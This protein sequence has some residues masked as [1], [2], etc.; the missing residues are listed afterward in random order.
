MSQLGGMAVGTY[1][2]F[3]PGRCQWTSEQTTA[4]LTLSSGQDE[5]GPSVSLDFCV[6]GNRIDTRMMLLHLA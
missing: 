1:W 2:L 3:R 5:E 4:P 6:I